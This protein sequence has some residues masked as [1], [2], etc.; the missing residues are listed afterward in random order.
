MVSKQTEKRKKT[1]TIAEY[2]E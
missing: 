1:Q 2:L